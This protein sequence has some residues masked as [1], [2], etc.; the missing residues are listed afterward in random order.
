[1]TTAADQH[2]WA[3]PF[4]VESFQ[5]K[6]GRDPEPC[7][8]QV[9]QGVGFLETRYG[10]GWQGAGAGSNNWAADQ[11]GRP[12]CPIATSFQYTDTHPNP[13]GT[14]TPYTI[15]F[16][17]YASPM[18]GASGLLRQVYE[19]RPS[20]LAAAN[21]CNIYGASAALHATH[22]YEGFGKTVAERIANH[23]RVLSSS[24]RAIA[25][26]LGE[27]YVD[28]SVPVSEPWQDDFLPDNPMI[29]KGSHGPYVKVWQR[30]LNEF[31]PD[32]G[33]LVV[34]GA[35]GKL[36]VADTKAFQQIKGLKVDGV[37]GPK[38]WGAAV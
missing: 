36:T 8:A 37:V 30:V 13:D 9:V 34:D 22:Y 4:I 35:F 20:V 25:T 3:R 24:V 28:S 16:R 12:P 17:R 5:A 18:E 11:S 32:G 14:S 21:A 2:R 38:T 23:Y 15:C 31:F 10:K 33:L 1:M 26:A 6:Y 7:E 29:L 19:R 27:T